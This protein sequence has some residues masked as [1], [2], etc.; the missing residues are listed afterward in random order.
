MT[1]G[2]FP[3]WELIYA[4]ARKTATAEEQARWSA[5][6]QLHPDQAALPEY[7]MELEAEEPH[8]P[9]YAKD[10][11]EQLYPRL[12]ER[13]YPVSPEAGGRLRPLLSLYRKIAAVAAIAAG[14]VFFAWS[15]LR[16]SSR[17]P[18]L[19]VVAQKMIRVPNG[20]RR[21]L[22]L[23]DSSLLWINAGSVVTIPAQWSDTAREITLEGE[24]FFEIKPD[25]RRP[26]FVHTHNAVIKVLGTSFNIHAYPYEPVAVTVATG[27]VLLRSTTSGAERILIKNERAILDLDSNNFHVSDS[28]ADVWLQWIKGRLQFRD[29]PLR[30]VMRTLER[31]YNT[32]LE[33]RGDSR[34]LYC[35][36]RYEADASLE[37]IL[38]SLQAVYNF[39]IT[40][41]SDHYRLTLPS[42]HNRVLSH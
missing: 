9:F 24:G 10:A 13:R 32:T 33:L 4:I 34:E 16:V 38:K 37:N 18:R 35:T 36:A 8:S 22:L 21:Q 2:P 28:N 23:P 40:R 31:H 3:E 26:F 15:A 17:G 1:K 42:G 14:L 41:V 11:Y 19:P 25:S 20:A 39:H 30:E 27:K 6:L 29:S 5:W 7:I 12:Q